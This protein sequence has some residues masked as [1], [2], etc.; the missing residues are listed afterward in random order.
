MHKY[1]HIIHI[2]LAIQLTKVQYSVTSC[3]SHGSKRLHHCCT[4]MIQLYS[5][6]GTNVHCHGISTGSAIL[7]GS[8]HAMSRRL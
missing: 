8:V 5:L 4:Q 3:Y 7:H 6:G 1:N 2:Q